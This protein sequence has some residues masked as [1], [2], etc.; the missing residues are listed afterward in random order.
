MK[1]KHLMISLLAIAVAGTALAQEKGAVESFL[2]KSTH[3]DCAV[4]DGATSAPAGGSMDECRPMTGIESW[5][6]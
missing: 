6:G 1:I 5:D 3:R 2:S 4:L